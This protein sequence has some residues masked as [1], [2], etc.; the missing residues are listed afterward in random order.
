MLRHTTIKISQWF[1]CL[2]LRTDHERI[3]CEMCDV[4]NNGPLEIVEIY[5]SEFNGGVD[6]SV[7]VEGDVFY[8]AIGNKV[9]NGHRF[10]T[11]T[12]VHRHRHDV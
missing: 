4:T 11:S 3:Y 2:V 1:E 8:W 9:V 6:H 10:D 5:R 12:M 7:L